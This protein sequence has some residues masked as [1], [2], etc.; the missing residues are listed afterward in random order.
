MVDT[1]S[2]VIHAFWGRPN[3]RNCASLTEVM[4]KS[5]LGFVPAA[6]VK[7]LLNNGHSWLD[8]AALAEFIRSGA[9]AH[10]LHR[11]RLVYRS[12]RDALLRPPA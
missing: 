4:P 9:F 6:S 1:P 2:T 3:A 8:Q 5:R 11:I 12:R 10:H 7:S